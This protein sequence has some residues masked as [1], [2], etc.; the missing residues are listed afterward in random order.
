[1]ST[2]KKITQQKP[3]PLIIVRKLLEKRQKRAIEGDSTD[4]SYQQNTTLEYARKM[5]KTT[6]YTPDFCQRLMEKFQ[7]DEERA[8]QIIDVNPE[9]TTELK[10]FFPA[11]SEEKLKE[12][13]EFYLE[14]RAKAEL[15]MEKWLEDEFGEEDE[16]IISYW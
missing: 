3:I 12:Y 8:I 6:V 7:V 9:T 4:F 15:E 1:M 2:S 13:L 14:E 5:S 11:I 16:E 10:P